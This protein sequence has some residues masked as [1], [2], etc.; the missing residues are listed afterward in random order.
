MILSGTASDGAAGAQAVKREGGKTLA[1]DPGTAKYAGMPENAIATGAIDFVLPLPLLAR[2]LSIIAGRPDSSPLALEEQIDPASLSAGPRSHRI[3]WPWFDPLL[4]PISANYKRSTVIRRIGRRMTMRHAE[5]LESY[6]ELLQDD[7][8]EVEALYQD[9]LI[10]VTSFFRQPAVFETLK[11]KIFPQIVG[12]SAGGQ[13][14]FW[15]PGCSSGEEAY[16]LAI[17]WTEF[18]GTKNVRKTSLQCLP[19]T[20]TKR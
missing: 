5:D 4:R 17:A 14:R 6:M 13:V 7:P 1:Q 9:L 2:Q 12:A 8:A 18:Q 19:A 15:V 20:S 3:F 10:R 11:E 16:S